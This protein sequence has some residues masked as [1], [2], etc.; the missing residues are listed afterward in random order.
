ML[1]KNVK[2]CDICNE[3]VA[4]HKCKLCTKD[5]CKSC[6]YTFEVSDITSST[7]G[8]SWQQGAS[9]TTSK[10]YCHSCKSKMWNVLRKNY[11]YRVVNTERRAKLG[12]RLFEILKE[13]VIVE[14]I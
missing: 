3:K 2:I 14:N 6:A 1:K 8:L 7:M 13:T 11:D 10:G 5:L 4:L 12:E 9:L